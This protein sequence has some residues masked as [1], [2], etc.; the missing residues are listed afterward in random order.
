MPSLAQWRAAGRAFAHRGH[1]IFYR[2]EGRA[3]RSDAALLCIHGFPTA[4]W[5][6]Q[7]LWSEL[8]ARFPRVIAADMIGF[9]F[10]A[11]PAG[12]DY[13]IFDQADLHAALLAHLGVRRVHLLA[14]DYGDT[15]AQELL[16]REL[17]GRITIDS[18]VLLNG[19]LFP[20]AHHPRTIQ[21]LL[22][23]PLGP[24]I[25]RLMNRR[26]FGRSF[27]AI[28][29]ARTQPTA[30]ELDD[31]WELI[32]THDGTRIFHRLIRY[33]PERRAHRA[34]WV[35]ALQQTRVP[36]RVIDGADDPVSGAHMVTRYRELVPAPDTV[37]LEGIGHYPQVEDPRGV[38][39]AFGEFHDRLAG[40]R[41]S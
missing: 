29:G 15:V 22:L 8:L 37:L 26:A 34:R 20:E 24:V 31:F 38:L 9:G 5:D 21:K 39:R 11:K 12:Y 30:A 17:E 36:L 10:S 28:F 13:S 27:A 3:P 25:G 4:S 33:M 40:R 18:C 7:P 32:R 1:D 23:T 14:H 6:W 2:D 41:S 19:G 35:G 16:A